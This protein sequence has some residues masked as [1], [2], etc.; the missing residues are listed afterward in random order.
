[1]PEIHPYEVTYTCE[2]RP[3][4]PRDEFGRATRTMLLNAYTAEDALL[5][6]RIARRSEARKDGM[7]SAEIGTDPDALNRLFPESIC[8]AK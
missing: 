7:L 2:A 8:P 4:E 5:Q 6:W 1:M 3:G